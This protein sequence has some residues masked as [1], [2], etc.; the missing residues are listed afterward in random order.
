MGGSLLA[1]LHTSGLR[2]KQREERESRD[3]GLP[4]PSSLVRLAR[5]KG[6]ALS[7]GCLKC[8]AGAGTAAGVQICE[9]GCFGVGAGW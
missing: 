3:S 2:V 6:F 5:E 1:R 4:V 8:P 9:G 7:V